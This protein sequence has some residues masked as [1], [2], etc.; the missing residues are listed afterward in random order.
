MERANQTLQDRLVKEM[1]LEG[2][3]TME[4]AQAYAPSFIAF[5]NRKFAIEHSRHFDCGQPAV[6][7]RRPSLS[8]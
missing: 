2:I 3:S 5:W 1:R 8:S 7:R 4:Q 6:A